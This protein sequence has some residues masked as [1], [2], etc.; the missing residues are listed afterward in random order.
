MNSRDA[1][2]VF[3]LLDG[4]LRSQHQCFV[5]EMFLNDA[6]TEYTLCLRPLRV[7]GG[8][9]NRYACRYVRLER[10]EAENVSQTEVLTRAVINTLENNVRILGESL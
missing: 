7:D 1:R 10:V 9:P 8:S 6:K 5:A 4:F 3:Q 2:L